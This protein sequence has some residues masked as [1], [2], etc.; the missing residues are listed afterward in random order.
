V[1]VFIIS[2][3]LIAK[4]KQIDSNS[5]VVVGRDK[6]LDSFLGIAVTVVLLFTWLNI[7]YLEGV[8]M[9][10]IAALIVTSALVSA[11]DSVLGL[12]DVSIREDEVDNI[13][14]LILNDDRIHGVKNI[15]IRKAGMYYFGE[16]TIFLPSKL[17]ID[18][19]SYIIKDTRSRLLENVRKLAQV[20]VSIDVIKDSV[21]ALVIPISGTKQD[22][23][24]LLSNHFGRANYFAFI[25][26]DTSTREII[27][28]FFKENEYKKK[29]VRTGLA[30]IKNLFDQKVHVV[31][32]KN[33]GDISFI[34]LQQ[35]LIE[36]FRPPLADSSK[37]ISARD[38]IELYLEGA[39]EKMREPTREKS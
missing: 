26:V 3:V 37:N 4:G 12:L 11:K 30:V 5:L 22:L 14:E 33:I 25:T 36:I 27:N 15:K 1:V 20:H 6:F 23:D 32:T 16:I 31:I 2:R 8:L 13:K 24:A 29:E 9:L 21:I 18:E 39:L 28:H 38:A 35:K 10:V 7:P 17:D 19:I 34:T